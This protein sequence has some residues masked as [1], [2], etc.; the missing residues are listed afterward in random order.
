VLLLQQLIVA[1]RLSTVMDADIIVVL[2][3]G[4]VR[5]SSTACTMPAL[6]LF[7]RQFIATL[8]CCALLVCLSI[9][10][11]QTNQYNRAVRQ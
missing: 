3:R 5:I 11:L 7:L 1:H 8:F 6:T 2:E 9:C 4:K 10:L